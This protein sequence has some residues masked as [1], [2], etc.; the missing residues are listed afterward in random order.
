MAKFGVN[1]KLKLKKQTESTMISA[2]SLM[3]E[4]GC[5]CVYEMNLCVSYAYYMYIKHVI[6]VSVYVLDG[7]VDK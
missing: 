1:V 7:L 4:I 2:K 3:S 6:P 5:V